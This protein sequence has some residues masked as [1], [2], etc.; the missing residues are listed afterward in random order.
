MASAAL[1]HALTFANMVRQ[2]LTSCEALNGIHNIFRWQKNAVFTMLAYA[3]TF[4]ICAS[5]ATI[6]QNMMAAIAVMDMYRDIHPEAGSVVA[7]ARKLAE[8]VGTVVGG[9]DPDKTSPQSSLSSALLTPRTIPAVGVQGSS[10][11]TMITTIPAV[12]AAPGPNNSD[13]QQVVTAAVDGG[14]GLSYLDD[15]IAEDIANSDSM[16]M[17]LDSL[18]QSDGGFIHFGQWEDTAG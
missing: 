6:R 4:P 13:K 9:F 15:M 18:D 1:N 11:P 10:Y 16:E 8:D 2:A 17:L 14:L 7:I 5:A 12:E 3:Y